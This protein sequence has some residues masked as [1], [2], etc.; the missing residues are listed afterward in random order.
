[1]ATLIVEC[2]VGDAP[3]PKGELPVLRLCA[4]DNITLGNE[5]VQR[6]NT[7]VRFNV[8]VLVFEYDYLRKSQNV[9]LKDVQTL[10]P[11]GQEV[12]IELECVVPKGVETYAALID[13]GT[14]IV[15]V[16]PLTSYLDEFKIVP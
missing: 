7:G 4:Y 8:P 3:R 15:C 5:E 1:M 2:S 14:S 13:R 9:R 16:V 11:A 10:V 6:V 12:M